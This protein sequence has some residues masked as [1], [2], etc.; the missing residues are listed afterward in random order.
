MDNTTTL[1]DMNAYALAR[2]AGCSDPQSLTSPGGIFLTN[3]RDMTLQMLADNDITERRVWELSESA[4]DV[5]NHARMQEF[6]DLCAWQEDITDYTE[7]T[8]DFIK[9]AGVALMIIA[10]RLVRALCE[11]ADI[12]I[13]D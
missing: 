6:T 10:E 2:L 8:G 5:Y 3:V 7:P 11:Q 12:E 9:D 13:Q 1:T 4:P